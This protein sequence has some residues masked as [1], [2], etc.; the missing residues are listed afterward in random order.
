[1]N[2]MSNLEQDSVRSSNGT[3]IAFTRTGHGPS[4]VI[5]HGS[6]VSGE[7]WLPVAMKLANRFTCHLMDRRGYGRSGDSLEYS[8]NREYE[9]IEA[10][11][12]AAGTQVSLLGHSYGAICAL[13]AATR[14]QVTHLVLYEPPLPVSH[15][16]GSALK[17][18]KRAIESGN[19]DG[20]LALGLTQFAGVAPEQI[21][22]LRRSPLW[23]KM[24]AL[25]PSW[26]R[27]VEAVDGLG[28]SLNRYRNLLVP[29]LLLAGTL[30]PRYPLQDASK[31]LAATLKNVQYSRL[32]GQ[33]HNANF[34]AP[35]LVAERVVSFLS[36]R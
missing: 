2:L 22:G 8:I 30:S 20:A 27:E 14:T 10:V 16:I 12:S 36:T 21:Q 25:A 7:S 13:G 5:V 11:I 18:Y 4:L 32:E 31:A 28:P 3:Q 9:D 26:S 23:T 1:M 6:L 35:T 24:A 29:T 19:L 34:L 15:P 33:G 17:D